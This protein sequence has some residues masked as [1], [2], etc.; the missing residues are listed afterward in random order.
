PRDSIHFTTRFVGPLTVARSG[1]WLKLDFPAWGT[2]SVTPPSL[3]LEA[4]GITE[5]KDMRVGRDYMV[6]LDNQ[7]QVDALHPNIHAMIPL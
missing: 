1:E 4:L 6:V 7:Q 5:Y 2:E 3:L